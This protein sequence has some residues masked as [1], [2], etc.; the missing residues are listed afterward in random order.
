MTM[1]GQNTSPLGFMIEI[2]FEK[3]VSGVGK[4]GIRSAKNVVQPEK[5]E[6]HL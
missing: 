6:V 3:P 5:N 4:Q 2:S 1:S